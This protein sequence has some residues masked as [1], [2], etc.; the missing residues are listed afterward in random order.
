M[1]L[2][3]PFIVGILALALCTFLGFLVYRGMRGSKR[4]NERATQ[5]A[6]EGFQR[7]SP[8]VH[9]PMGC[10]M[11][12]EE[13]AWFAQQYRYSVRE[14][15]GA[16]RYF[17]ILVPAA[18]SVGVGGA[19]PHPPQPPPQ[20]VG[21]GGA[22]QCQPPP[23]PVPQMPRNEDVDGLRAV[24]QQMGKEGSSKSA[25]YRT[26]IVAA[27]GTVF[28]VLSVERFVANDDAYLA[29][30]LIAAVFYFASLVGI[31]QFL[32]ARKAARR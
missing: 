16:Y 1:D 18:P 29:L 26:A 8:E 7:G 5:R 28:C 25:L 14:W 11:S 4:S 27:V 12:P 10:G 20:I 22:W 21:E 15:P 9:L 30:G 32:A 17:Y 3:A 19:I 31:F 6:R 24:R 2:F 13:V 23:Q